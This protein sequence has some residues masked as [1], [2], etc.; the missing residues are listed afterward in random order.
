MLVFHGRFSRKKWTAKHGKGCENSRNGVQIAGS[1]VNLPNMEATMKAKVSVEDHH[2]ANPDALARVYDKMARKFSR[3]GFDLAACSAM[4]QYFD[5][6]DGASASEIVKV[7]GRNDPK[8]LLYSQ[9]PTPLPPQAVRLCVV[10]FHREAPELAFLVR[11]ASEEILSCL[12]AGVKRYLHD[13]SHYHITIFMTSQPHTLRPNPFKSP[14]EAALKSDLSRDEFY[15]AAQP[16]P[17]IVER[18][19]EI[20]K[21][22]AKNTEPP[23]FYIHRIVVADSGTVLLLCINEAPTRVSSVRTKAKYRNLVEL[24]QHFRSEFPGAPPK[25]SS[26]FHASLARIFAFQQLDSNTKTKI[27]QVADEWSNRLSGLRFHVDSLSHVCEDRFTAVDGP[28]VPL[29]F[30]KGTGLES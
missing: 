4:A 21:V 23:V 26:I 29:P 19:I 24:R 22:A 3:H 2:Q 6:N 27:Q 20:M 14:S 17:A 8:P 9:F 15:R 11:K 7:D 28:S 12:P 16:D 1:S 30:E 5:L 25:Q 10:F 18:E 13:P